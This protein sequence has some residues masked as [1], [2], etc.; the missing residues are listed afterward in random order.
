MIILDVNISILILNANIL[1]V[2]KIT[3]YL[4]HIIWLYN[5]QN[6]YVR[7]IKLNI[8]Q[9]ILNVNTN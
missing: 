2:N 3:V 6:E 9:F 4:L 5:M 8:I 7:N 1:D